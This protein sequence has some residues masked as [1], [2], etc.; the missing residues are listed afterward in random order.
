MRIIK[1][2][3][4]QEPQEWEHTCKFCDCVFMYTAE[5]V[6][7]NYHRTVRYVKCPNCRNTIPIYSSY[8]KFVKNI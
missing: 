6:K 3:I 1:Q 2:G 4:P 5:D 8:E 7:P